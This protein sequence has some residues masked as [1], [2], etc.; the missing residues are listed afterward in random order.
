MVLAGHTAS[1]VAPEGELPEGSVGPRTRGT[2]LELVGSSRASCRRRTH[3]CGEE[4]APPP[5]PVLGDADLLQDAFIASS[6]AA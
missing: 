5:R 2:C 4:F 6:H 3:D 1:G